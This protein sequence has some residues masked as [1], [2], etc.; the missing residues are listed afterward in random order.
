M[1]T[2]PFVAKRLSTMPTMVWEMSNAEID[3]KGKIDIDYKQEIAYKHNENT[4]RDHSTEA[5]AVCGNTANNR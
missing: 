3:V 1:R 4:R 5:P 2:S